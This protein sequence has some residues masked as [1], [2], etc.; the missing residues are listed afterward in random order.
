MIWSLGNQIKFCFSKRLVVI[1]ITEINDGALRF[2]VYTPDLKLCSSSASIWDKSSDVM[3]VSW[4]CFLVILTARSVASVQTAEH[5]SPKFQF[6]CLQFH[7]CLLFFI[8]FCIH[9]YDKLV[10]A[11]SPFSATFL[12]TAHLHIFSVLSFIV[13][14]EISFIKS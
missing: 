4:C 3:F 14:Y 12:Q 13:Y 5:H 9:W 1:F 11:S 2:L 7:F 10:Q 6:L 8:K